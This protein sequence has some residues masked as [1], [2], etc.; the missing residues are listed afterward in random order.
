MLH[1]VEVVDDGDA[2]NV[3]P[4]LNTMHF[5]N[6]ESLTKSALESEVIDEDDGKPDNARDSEDFSE[7]MA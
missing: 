1:T 2:S 3:N 7:S 5:K 4:I 6:M